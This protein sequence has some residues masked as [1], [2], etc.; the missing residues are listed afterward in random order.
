MEPT[1]PEIENSLLK[2]ALWLTPEFAFRKIEVFDRVL[3]EKMKEFAFE[4]SW[5]PNQ[6]IN[7]SDVVGTTDLSYEGKTWMELLRSGGRMP[8]NLSLAETNPDYYHGVKKKAPKMSYIKTD[9]KLYID[10]DGHHRSC[11][12]K[13][14]FYFAIRTHLHGVELREY[15]IAKDIYRRYSGIRDLLIEKGLAHIRISPDRKILGTDETVEGIKQIFDV[16]LLVINDRS[17]EVV[18]LDSNSSLL[19]LE[20]V[21]RLGRLNKYWIGGRLGRVLRR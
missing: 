14:L 11:I 8:E 12:A 19:F 2:K 17:S 3:F 9:G 10:K 15:Q 13:F 1:H 5:R 18:R 16:G 21:H 20:I 7:I 6:S 4:E